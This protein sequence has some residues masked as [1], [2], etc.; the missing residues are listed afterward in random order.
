MYCK[1]LRNKETDRPEQTNKQTNERTDKLARVCVGIIVSKRRTR[2]SVAVLKK[3]TPV[4]VCVGPLNRGTELC[5]RV[6]EKIKIKLR[7]FV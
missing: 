7:S 1:K 3:Q 6:A 4:R 5:R 2:V